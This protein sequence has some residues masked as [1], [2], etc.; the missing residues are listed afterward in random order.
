MKAKTVLLVEDDPLDVERVRAA[1]ASKGVVNELVVAYTGQ[2]ALDHLFGTGS[3][4]GHVPNKLP[5]LILLD[6]G[7]PDIGGLEILR[8]VR[9][10][11]HTSAIPVVILSSTTDEFVIN[12]ARRLGEFMRAVEQLRVQWI[13]LNEPSSRPPRIYLAG[14]E[15]QLRQDKA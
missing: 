11:P 5:A 8:K 14:T 3:S 2:K 15:E 9:A 6:L 1:L 13:S 12:T 4:A 10:T 7:L